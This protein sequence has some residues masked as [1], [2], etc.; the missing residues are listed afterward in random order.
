MP[1]HDPQPPRL[2]VLLAR[3]RRRGARARE[4][5]ADLRELFEAR[6][7]ERGVRY[8]RRAYWRD[9]LS[10]WTHPSPATLTRPMPDA[11]PQ[12]WRLDT[13]WQDIVFAGRLFRRQ[14]ATVALTVAGLA[15]AIGLATAV[16]SLLNAAALR[17]LGVADPDASVNVWHTWRGGA[18]TGWPYAE[19]LRAREAT[20][21]ST[22][23]GWIRDAAPLGLTSAEVLAP[24]TPVHLVTGGTF[25]TFGLRTSLGRGLTP[26]D[27][28]AGGPVV[29][30]VSHAFWRHRLG[31]DPSILGRRVYFFGEPAIVVGVADR[32]STGPA[33]D[34]P[35]FWV[36][37]A[38][39]QAIWSYHGPFHPGSPAPI[40]V[41]ARV[42]P[43]VPLAQAEA[44]LSAIV[45][46]LPPVSGELKPGTR[47]QFQPA[48]NRYVREMGII[49]G[50]V[51]TAVALVLL[52][53]CANVANLLLASAA[54]RER[55]IGVRLALGAGRLRIVRQLL[56]ESLTV[57]AIGG[58]LG[59]LAAIW[60]LPVLTTLAQ[61]PDTL[62]VAPDWRV[63]GFALLATLAAGIGAGL[64]PAKYGTRGQLLAALAGDSAQAGERPKGRWLRS[65]LVSTQATAS[66]LLLVLT[67]L[68]ARAAVE[69]HRID[70]GFD[71]D[72]IV[73]VMPGFGHANYDAARTAKYWNVALERVRALPGVSGAALVEHS[74]LGDSRRPTT[75][76]R[77]G[78]PFTVHEN[79][80]SAEYFATAGIR[81]V[82]G[83]AY[84][85]DEV[86][87]GAPVTVISESLAR[88]VWGGADPI[89]QTLASATKSASQARVVGV[90]ADTISSRLV[91]G[92]PHTIYRPLAGDDVV[93][94][95]IVVR[96][97]GEVSAIVRPLRDV[98]HAIDPALSVSVQPVR[99]FLDRQLAQ[100]RA[101]AAL[102]ALG[103][104]LALAL[105]LIGIFGVTT[106]VVSQRMR[107]VGIRIAIGATARDVVRLL[108]RDALQ[109]VVFGLALGLLGALAGGR[110]IAGALYGVSPRDPVAIAAA[111]A[112]LLIAAALAV[113]VPARRAARIDPV[114]ILRQG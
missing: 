35:A 114:A 70:L 2:A 68:L 102:A 82:R 54:S 92:P 101:L 28:R 107:E 81:L 34:V 83:R 3:L 40:S 65:G 84:S 113:L 85:P 50:V 52:L 49:I 39:A 25:S 75:W 111:V 32:S 108:L 79:R 1:S 19:Y 9:A 66:I 33:V 17:P 30:V 86:R 96:T 106:F 46:G 99:G 72:R 69:A 47:V 80:T 78:R 29:A 37:L 20:R 4:I 5:E 76:Q 93:F 43:G 97:D 36:P 56:T 88:A 26:D 42:T 103:G 44:E 13:M 62:D 95:R 7:A 60:L 67:A 51:M 57:A 45:A 104:G 61:A 105:A 21:L 74:P 16:F 10:L 11:A 71:A 38:P 15:L 91:E 14:P 12:H 8:A 89:G 41:R 55:E 98:V 112:V 53:A 64:A 110:I 109:P 27:D 87:D 23:E 94:G 6:S 48:D 22:L 31:G 59:L 63:Y 24:S 18:S 90:A 77:E 73:S 100:A 58:L